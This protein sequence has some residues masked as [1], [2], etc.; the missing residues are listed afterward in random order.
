M[1][2]NFYD[3][4]DEILDAAH[5]GHKRQWT[6]DALDALYGERREVVAK[7]RDAARAELDEVH[8]QA[9]V[10]REERAGIVRAAREVARAK[11]LYFEQRATARA[12]ARKAER[13]RDEARE[14]VERLRSELG[15][16]R[17][18]LAA[19]TGHHPRTAWDELIRLTYTDVTGLRS[20]VD[21]RRRDLSRMRNAWKSA[22]AGRARERQQ[23]TELRT[24]MVRL[25][26]QLRAWQD[27]G[28][29]TDIEGDVRDALAPLADWETAT[30][31]APDWLV[32]VV[33]G[34]ILPIAFRRDRATEQ[35]QRVKQVR[36][37][38]NEDGNG[39]VFADDLRAAVDGA[40]AGS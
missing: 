18:D 12:L 16:R 20:K 14:Q 35:L 17:R 30:G 29:T 3:R 19:V 6:V 22:R 13:E 33:V 7:E 38:R 39:F 5:A 9:A 2:E 28:D 37:W 15:Q 8:E 11:D 21:Q 23:R 40:E 27:A 26:A 25:T 24:E 1:A 34:L 31:N 10:A 36:V 32:T 4:L